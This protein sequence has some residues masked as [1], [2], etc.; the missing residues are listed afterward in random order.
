MKKIFKKILSLVLLFLVVIFIGF[1]VHN[2]WHDFQK[3]HIIS[4]WFLAGSII[5]VPPFFLVTALFFQK[6]VEPFGLRLSFNE[7]FGLTMFTLMGNYLIPFS[8]IGFRAIYM[9]KNYSFSYRNFL[10]T[11]IVGWVTILIIYSTAAIIALVF[12]YF[13]AHKIDWYLNIIFLTI[14][15]ISLFSFIPIKINTHYKILNYLTSWLGFWQDYIEN[16]DIL[17]KLFMLTFWQFF[18]ASLMFYF[19]YLTFGFKISFI[20]SFW[21]AT[22]S[23]YSSL[24]RLVPGS[25]GFYELAVAYPSTVLGLSP[26][27]GLSVAFITRIITFLWTFV[28]GG[29]FSYILFRRKGKKEMIE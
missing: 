12:Y 24:I 25:L 14:L 18:F 15:A 3:I 26:A 6:S 21:P 27:Q 9:K 17:R 2:H 20:D 1:Y 7:C 22:L 5:L 16:K 11:V 19:A 4:W 10:T 28:L 8:G 23:L 13:R 29:I